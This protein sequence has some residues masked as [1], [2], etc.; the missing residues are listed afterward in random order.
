MALIVKSTRERVVKLFIATILCLGLSAWCWYD[1]TYKYVGEE[2][3]ANRKFNT[4]AI[5]VLVVLGLI[6]LFYAL[7][8]A[9]LRI[10]ADEQTGISINGRPPITW[11]A[12]EDIDTSILAK[13]G[14][15]FV[16]YRDPQDNL[17]TLKLDEFNLDYF[18]E[19]YA[20]IRAKLGLPDESPDESPPSA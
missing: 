14:Y 5:P 3:D 15:L 20:M 16:K 17:T 9:R 10:E 12:I 2:H 13:R 11:D 19:L 8:A 18:A 4:A 7:K 6:G 1:I